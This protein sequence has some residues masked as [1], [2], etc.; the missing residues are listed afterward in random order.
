ME[1]PKKNVDDIISKKT[2]KKKKELNVSKRYRST[3]DTYYPD[4]GGSNERFSY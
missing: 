2:K 3:G 1:S 4:N